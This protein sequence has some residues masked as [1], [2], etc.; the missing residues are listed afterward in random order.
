MSKK[1]K[2]FSC[3]KICLLG[4][5][6]VGKS[7]LINRLIN[8]SFSKVYEPT[9]SMETYSFLFNLNDDDV[10]QKTYINLIIQDTFG[11]N[12]TILNK[13]PELIYSKNI[14]KIREKMSQDFKDIMFSSTEM[15]NK[16]MSEDKNAKNKKEP[17]YDEELLF[18]NLGYESENI[19]R[20][21]FIFVCDCEN[22]KTFDTVEKIIEKL[23]EIEKSNNL[24]YPK[25]ILFN[26]SDRIKDDEFKEYVQKKQSVLE[27]FKGKS[28]IDILKVSALTG[29]GVTESFKMFCTRIHQEEQNKK[30]NEG[31][32][33][34][35]DDKD[36]I[37][38]AGCS[39]KAAFYSKKIFCGKNLFS[40]GVSYK[41]IFNLL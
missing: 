5:T 11:L 24:K 26:K 3:I 20:S 35:D 19:P 28:K 41:Y 2:P 7:A 34:P 14:K 36:K 29:H 31:I 6:N 37:F 12:N 4:C 18:D 17:N 27:T 33:E 15:R 39:D 8:K 10:V 32:N 13:P 40:C 1:Q 9:M 21:G 25:M 38:E 16:L 23:E 30:Q 22:L